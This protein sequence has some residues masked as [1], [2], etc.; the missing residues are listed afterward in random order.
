MHLFAVLVIAMLFR[1]FETNISKSPDFRFITSSWFA[2]WCINT[3]IVGFLQ[4]S[5]TYLLYSSS[6]KSVAEPQDGGSECSHQKVRV[7]VVMVSTS[8]AISQTV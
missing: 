2:S 6:N 3:S 5:L 7:K 4:T 8:P 1:I